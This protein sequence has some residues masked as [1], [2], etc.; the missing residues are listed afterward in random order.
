MFVGYL[1]RIRFVSSIVF[2]RVAIV[3][4]RNCKDAKAAVTEM[5]GHS[6]QGHTLHVEHIHKSPADDQVTIK[7]SCVQ[8]Y[9]VARKAGDGPI[10]HSSNKLNASRVSITQQTLTY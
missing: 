6:I 4:V 10:T 2:F 3:S 9:P 8:L 5:N 1:S 7:E